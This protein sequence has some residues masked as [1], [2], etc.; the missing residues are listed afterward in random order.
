MIDDDIR[1]PNSLVTHSEDGYA[2]LQSSLQIIVRFDVHTRADDKRT[3][4]RQTTN[5]VCY[6]QLA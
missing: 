4:F 6:Q 2:S 1:F 3:R 5:L